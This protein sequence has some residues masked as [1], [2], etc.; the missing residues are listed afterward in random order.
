MEKIHA[1]LVYDEIKNP[2]LD[3]VNLV[4]LV[5]GTP[6]LIITYI[7]NLSIGHIPYISAFGLLVIAVLVIFRKT[8][9]YQ[10]KGWSLIVLGY[11]IGTTAL[12]NEGIMSDGL[13][14][15]IFIGIIATLL[16][17][18][19]SGLIIMVISILSFSAI[20]VA[21]SKGWHVFDFDIQKYFYSSETWLA[22]ILTAM[23]FL[24]VALYIYGRLESYLVRNI[25][26][27]TAQSKKLAHSKTRLEQEVIERKLT[28]EQLKQSENKFKKVFNSIGD[29]IL[30]L[31]PDHTVHNVN[32]SFLRM[33]G[34]PVN[35]VI[36]KPLESFFNDPYRINLLLKPDKVA[37]S[38]FNLSEHWLKIHGG[39][40]TIPVEIRI[41]PIKREEEISKIAIIKDISSSKE[42]EIKIM[43]AVINS[44][45][46]ERKRIAQDLHDSIGPYLSAAKLYVNSSALKGNDIRGGEIRKELS[47]L[48]HLAINSVREISGNLGSHV[49]RSAGLHASLHKFIEQINVTCSIAFNLQIP[50]TSPFVQNVEITLYRILVELINNSVKYS[51]ASEIMIKQSET[52]RTVLIEYIENGVGFDVA[53]ALDRHKG[54]G[55]YN[56]HNRISSLGGLVEYN[57]SPGN[58]V[59]V[60]ITFNKDQTF[61]QSN[62]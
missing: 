49:L 20:A 59:S 36:N 10:I 48:L 5:L 8:I 58:G 14:Y 7:N 22:Y 60:R 61:K 47:D 62:K 1:R 32:E 38:L 56:I 41:L 13:L 12:W 45:E 57:S 6:A 39:N 53:E 43:H 30:L 9:N 15:Y 51:S 54:M 44:E 55:L 4:T 24:S 19:R 17:N 35:S 21:V 16:I 27:L 50:V 33:T 46:E 25:S 28:E 37:S 3:S 11:M 34:L 31:R 26:E 42:T 23:L 18:I 40:E 29:G 52:D 2:I